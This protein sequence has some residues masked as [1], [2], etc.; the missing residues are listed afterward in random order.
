MAGEDPA[1]L[2][3]VRRLPC[4]V[5]GCRSPSEAHHVRRHA[6]TGMRPH[7]RDAIPMCH[8][9][10]VDEFHRA[11]GYFKGW[12]KASRWAWQEEQLQRVRPEPDPDAF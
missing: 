3:H 7:D 4:C 1:W 11:T 2:A 10:H 8:R 6:G 9:H 5:P 12:T